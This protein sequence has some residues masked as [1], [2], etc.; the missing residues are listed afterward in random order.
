MRG[1]AAAI[2]L[3]E[4]QQI[5]ED[6]EVRTERSAAEHNAWMQRIAKSKKEEQERAASAAEFERRQRATSSSSGASGSGGPVFT[7]ARSK[8][9]GPGRSG[10]ESKPSPA[11]KVESKPSS[12][13]KKALPEVKEMVKVYA[14]KPCRNHAEYL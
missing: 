12:S 8:I 11:K 6:T 3:Q 5:Q 2:G 7:G 14:V 1:A 4:E 13:T 10:V 9:Y